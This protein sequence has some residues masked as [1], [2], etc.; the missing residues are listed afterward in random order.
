MKS[1]HSYLSDGDYENDV[2]K[3]L[4]DSSG[5]EFNHWQAERVVKDFIKTLIEKD[6][7][8]FSGSDLYRF[9][10]L[11]NF[12]G[13]S[14]GKQEGHKRLKSSVKN[15]LTLFENHVEHSH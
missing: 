5:K 10:M 14:T 4:K 2:E 7:K 15:L 6:N 13:Y 11:L 8:S 3:Y 1:F 9:N 12:Q